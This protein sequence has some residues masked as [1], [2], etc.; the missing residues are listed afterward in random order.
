[1][2]CRWITPPPG[3]SADLPDSFGRGRLLPI[4]E[5]QERAFLARSKYGYASCD[6]S[7]FDR[8]LVK[9]A[10]IGPLQGSSSL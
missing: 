10:E 3:P 2:A 6:R 9:P 1:L 5:P 4:A 8:H 7:G